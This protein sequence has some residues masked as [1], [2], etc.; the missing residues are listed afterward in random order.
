[1]MITSSAYS[2]RDPAGQ[3]IQL[4]QSV[5]R[6][7]HR[8]SVEEFR[9]F[10]HSNTTKELVATGRLV[11]TDELVL[12]DF[13]KK[14]R[15][16]G[17]AVADESACGLALEHGRVPF[18]SFPAEWPPEMLHAAGMLTLD[19]AD[20]FL[21]EGIGLKDAT[22]YNVLFVGPEPIFIDVLSFEDRNENDPTWVAYAQFVRTFLLPLLVK[23]HF[24]LSHDKFFLSRRDGIEPEKIY[25]MTGIIRRLLPPF[26][27]LVSLPVWLSK[28]LKVNDSSIYQPHLIRDPDKATYI[29]R[30]RF[31]KLRK[32][33]KS[34]QP[35]SD[36]N[37]DW[38]DYLINNNNYSDEQFAAKSRFVDSALR[39]YAPKRVLD[40]GCNTGYFSTIA[41]HRGASVVAIDSDPVV[42]GK[43]WSTARQEKLDILPL[44]VNLTRPTAA[45]GWRNAETP[46]FLE[47]AAGA[48]DAVLMLAV[49]HHM[50]VSEG[51]PL[52]EIIALA[53]QLTTDL[54][55]IEFVSAEDSMFKR[56][57]RGRD[58][59]YKHFTQ[60]YF[61]SEC[62]RYFEII[63]AR[64]F[65]GSN[66]C[67]Y[68]M[69]IKKS[70]S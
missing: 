2:F 34:L 62:L 12:T 25:A 41:A 23:A 40:V 55:I 48:F 49:V 50:I 7:V 38:C 69:R 32:L 53:A 14:L 56:L 27:Q 58:R 66:R 52:P 4:D 16:R 57:T 13:I 68:V 36:Q 67:L 60:K 43:V 22:P 26:L 64:S 33:M 44:V 30:S 29:L 20:V 10:F 9:H 35:A 19:L 42:V 3:V 46:S 21:K 31:A 1:M 65:N 54:L 47:R 11:N 37:S 8:E 59:L 18:V 28:R 39:E 15:E 24:G 63:E 17:I 45:L 6:L 70:E 51:I 5:F 61:E